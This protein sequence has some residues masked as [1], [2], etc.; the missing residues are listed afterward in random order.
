M[1]HIA[2][3][4]GFYCVVFNIW[5]VFCICRMITGN[6]LTRRRAICTKNPHNTK[7]VKVVVST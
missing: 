6:L 5:A 3:R 1:D 4:Y 2:A 7:I